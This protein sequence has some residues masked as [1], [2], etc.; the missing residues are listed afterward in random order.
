MNNTMDAT[1][2][3]IVA[4]SCNKSCYKMEQQEHY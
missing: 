3:V 1:N 4:P 2:S